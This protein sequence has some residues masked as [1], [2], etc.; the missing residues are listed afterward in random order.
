MVGQQCI[1]RRGNL[2]PRLIATTRLCERH[3]A[4]AASRWSHGRLALVQSGAVVLCRDLVQRRDRR[5]RIRSLDPSGPVMKLPCRVSRNLL[6]LAISTALPLIAVLVPGQSAAAAEPAESSTPQ[7]TPPSTQ[8]PGPRPNV[9]LICVDDL[10]PALGCY[11]DALARTPNI[12]RLA[13][14]AVLFERA[15]CNQ[16]VCSPSR[17]SLLVGLRPQTL[18]IYHLE[19]NFR[20]ARADAVTLP[21][22]FKQHGYRT[23]SLGKVFH[24]GH[25]NQDDTASWSVPSWKPDAA[26]Y[27]LAESRPGA[28]R[29]A[30]RAARAN[31]NGAANQG[32]N[33]RR[34]KGAAYEAADVP[35]NTYGDGALTDEAIVRLRAAAAGATAD[36]NSSPADS[37]SGAP[38]FLAVGFV[39]PHLPFVS[40][41]KYWDQFDRGKFELA[42][43]QTPPIGAPSYA[44][45]FGGELRNYL[46]MPKSGRLDDELQRTLIHGY[47]AAASYMDAQV[48][49]VLDELER[50]GLAEN[51]IVV[52][53]GDHG[54]HLGDHG[55]WCKHTNYEQ[56]ARIPLL[57]SAPSA[58]TSAAAGVTSASL[59]ESVDLYPTLCQLAGLTIPAGLDGRSFV[60]TLRDPSAPAR[61]YAT[62]VYPRVG[63]NQQK[64][65]GRAVR[66]ARYRLVEWK[67]FGAA[68]ESAELELYDYTSDPLETENLAAQQPAVVA[69]LRAL[70]AQQPEALPQVK[71]RGG[72]A[73]QAAI[74]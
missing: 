69:E 61:D 56:A 64:L 63:L 36:E 14:R 49:R 6:V 39:R 40:P 7:S 5:R 27:A 42:K 16:A 24:V 9:L 58:A 11:G 52:L 37:A 53:W 65:L 60:G 74:E 43:L 57:I 66:T 48:G 4:Q 3:A 28:A 23:Q 15:Y 30:Q 20:H 2:P 70:L 59:V 8:Q 41:Q 44:P 17:N 45:Q 31:Q 51:T 19:T 10:K 38:W 54:W 71:V 68:P 29:R 32:G 13:K 34:A 21:Q 55:I 50:L 25:G 72:N 12:D 67:A 46:G 47:Y 22:Y 26:A 62:H 18:G 33:Q 1:P 73:D 35:D